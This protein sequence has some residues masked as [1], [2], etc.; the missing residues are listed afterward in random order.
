M[1]TIL[2]IPRELKSLENLVKLAK[3]KRDEGLKLIN[4]TKMEKPTIVCR[5]NVHKN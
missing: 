1:E 5:I 4:F 3:K 2:V